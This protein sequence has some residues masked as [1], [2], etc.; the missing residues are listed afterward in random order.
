MCCLYE[1]LRGHQRAGFE[2]AIVLP[3]YH[4]F[5]DSRTPLPTPSGSEFAVHTAPCA[6]LPTIKALRAFALRFGDGRE[7]PYLLRWC[8]GMTTWTLMTFSLFLAAMRVTWRTK[9]RFDAVYAHNEYA[10]IAGYLLRVALRIPNVTRLY[11]TFV[12]H[13]MKKPLV[14]LRYPVAAGG[15]LVPHS[16][17]ICANDGIRGDEVARRFRLDLKR[18][19]FWQDGV[20]RPSPGRVASREDFLKCAPAN[21]RKDSAWVLSCSRMDAWKRIDRIIRA[22]GIARKAGCDCQLLAAGEGGEKQRLLSL[23]QEL[24]L[25]DEIVWLGAVP[26][27]DVWN[28]M[29]LA[30]VFVIANDV[31]NRCNPLFEAIRAG[32]PVVSVRDPSTQDLLT[33]HDNALLA[34]RDDGERLGECLAEVCKDSGL[35]QRM[36]LAQRSREALLW[37]WEERMDV[38][39]KELAQ[40]VQNHNPSLRGTTIAA[41]REDHT[42]EH[43]V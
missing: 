40:L 15:F 34:E 41:G 22:V 20:D 2:V 33:D 23:V 43:R 32:L 11:G 35:A 3:G 31:T 7:P 17:L 21:L 39:V 37:T 29:N 8:L 36:R 6:W 26:H 12:A 28:L 10:A 24:G 13:L 30:D 14:W 25:H 9:Q 18:F 4:L 42:K 16:L 1:T 5:D 38:E 19:R 27:D